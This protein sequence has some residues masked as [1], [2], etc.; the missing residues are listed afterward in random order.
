MSPTTYFQEKLAF[1][2]ISFLIN[3][4]LI[5]GFLLFPASEI[6]NMPE[7]LNQLDIY[8]SLVLVGPLTYQLFR[9]FQKTGLTVSHEGIE[10]NILR[11]KTNA[12]TWQTITQ[13]KTLKILYW[14][15]LLIEIKD[16]QGF[17]KEQNIF[18]RLPAVYNFKRYGTPI[19]IPIHNTRT[20]LNV[21]IEAI[22]NCAQGSR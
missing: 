9:V 10:E 16:P 17:I 12:Y 13:I 1:K 14:S 18:F 11:Y 5:F 6:P 15:Y 8:I 4:L 22:R 21:V 20:P 2:L 7:W 3:V 19:K